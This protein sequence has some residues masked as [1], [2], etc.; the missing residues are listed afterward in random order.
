M[1]TRNFAVFL[2]MIFSGTVFGQNNLTDSSYG[3]N[4]RTSPRFDR[5]VLNNAPSID[6]KGRLMLFRD[7][8]LP[9]GD[10]A[11]VIYRF[12]TT[13]QPDV[14][15]NQNGLV[16]INITPGNTSG[17]DEESYSPMFLADHRVSFFIF[18]S[19]SGAWIRLNENGS[20]D[21]AFGTNGRLNIPVEYENAETAINANN[22]TIAAQLNDE[23]GVI[24]VSRFTIA[25]ALDN[26]FGTGGKINIHSSI[27]GSPAISLSGLLIDGSG[28]MIIA[29]KNEKYELLVVRLN[30]NGSPDNS[31]GTNGH[32]EYYAESDFFEPFNFY[33][34]QLTTDG[35]LLFAGTDDF[36]TTA[37]LRLTSAGVPDATFGT[38]GLLT[39]PFYG[40]TRIFYSASSTTGPAV[41]LGGFEKANNFYKFTIGKRTANGAADNSFGNAGF[42]TL[43]VSTSDAYGL[44]L[45]ELPGNK[46]MLLGYSSSNGYAG[47]T[48]AQ[49]LS[50]G[51][52]DHTFGNN[53]ILYFAGVGEREQPDSLL[54]T[55]AITQA[56]SGPGNTTLIAGYFQDGG[57]TNGAIFV[58]RLKENGNRDSSFGANGFSAITPMMGI[59]GENYASVKMATQ[60][61]GKLIVAGPV[62]DIFSGFVLMVQRLTVL[63]FPDNNFG[64]GGRTLIAAG[65]AANPFAGFELIDLKVA[66]NGKT[67]IIASSENEDNGLVVTQVIQLN[68]SGIPDNTFSGDGKL[69]AS[70]S[71][72]M[73]SYNNDNK[74]VLFGYKT[75]EPGGCCEGLAVQRLNTNGAADNTFNG[76]LARTIKYSPENDE[77]VAIIIGTD[78]AV[79]LLFFPLNSDKEY[80]IARVTATGTP[81]AGWGTNGILTGD[82]PDFGY[83]FLGNALPEGGYLFA[84]SGDETLKLLKTTAA[85]MPDNGFGIGGVGTVTFPGST[86]FDLRGLLLQPGG[87]VMAAGNQ[88]IYDESGFNYSNFALLTRLKISASIP[89]SFTLVNPGNWDNAAN[90]LNGQ[91]P[92]SV[93][94]AGTEVMINPG[95]N[96]EAILNMNVTVQPGGKITVKPG[97]KL[98]VTSNLTVPAI[99]T[100]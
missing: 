98:I 24:T 57:I 25:G 63:G 53:G 37:A 85:G 69:N 43:N 40:G 92:P 20:F 60:P 9:G 89:T 80:A 26:S 21:Q 56:I 1:K 72:I 90:W 76:G 79:T 10:P 70:F 61:D 41:W 3:L 23:D 38:N 91:M 77:P 12:S 45:N 36:T 51:S 68:A 96:G 17:D 64:S 78:Q 66:P 74:M 50:T 48:A 5:K 87:K 49:L 8:T 52:L 32:T 67:G 22:Q 6:K 35:K 27:F 75:K 42:A 16:V 83:W 30:D 11:L 58:G 97:K 94:A 46:L 28:K 100:H 95:G 13:G 7:T 86:F 81:L 62:Y 99:T 44:L 29:G 93:I 31:F 59:I 33:Q 73:I 34:P 84:S 47:F 55:T 88:L 15:F 71:A 19:T 39:L 4:G 65:G 54:L 2:L 14:S 82:L 18:N